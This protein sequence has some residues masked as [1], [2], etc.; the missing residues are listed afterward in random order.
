MTDGVRIEL[1]LA[2]KRVE[3]IYRHDDHG[4]LTSIN[5]WDGGAA[6][7]FF[8]MRAVGGLICRFRADLPGDLVS[9][10]EALCGTEPAGDLSGKLPARYAE[11]LELLSSHAPVDRVW[12][13]P[14]YM[15]TRDLPPSSPPMAVGDHDAHLL[16]GGFEDWMPD[17][18]HRRP[19]MAVI[20]NDHAVSLCAS[21]R[22]SDAVHCAGVE[23]RADH[24]RRGHAVNAVAGWARAARSLGATP[25]YSTSWDNVASQGVA[26][27]LQL[28]LVGVD[29]HLT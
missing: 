6:P 26:R 29:F 15:S 20:E 18:P 28:S 21:V 22:I 10:L 3:T 11:Y 27:R 14:A 16:R 7:R 23:T 25:F 17:V 13:G 12:A 19:F 1:D 9:R 4:R 24:R 8:L 5:Q 2:R